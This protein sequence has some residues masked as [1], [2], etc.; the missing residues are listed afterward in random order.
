MK[1]EDIRKRLGQNIKTFRRIRK[2]T[3]SDLADKTGIS[4][5]MLKSIEQ[6]RTGTSD[7]Y[8]V[9]IAEALEVDVVHLLM[10]VDDS[11]DEEGEDISRIKQSIAS[12]L[13]A[14][15]DSTLDNLVKPKL[16]ANSEP[17]YLK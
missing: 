14:Y 15:V 16:A 3:Q 6:A 17:V 11:F 1:T 4:L 12:G 13:K 10:P 5:D 7:K 2:F 8:L 9:A